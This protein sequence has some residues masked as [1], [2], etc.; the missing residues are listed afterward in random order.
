MS[1]WLV[2]FPDTTAPQVVMDFSGTDPQP[3]QLVIAGWVVDRKQAPA[4]DVSS[5][6][7][8]EVWVRPIA[9]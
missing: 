6:Y 3:G 9:A 8:L 2:H 1:P 4:P 7:A 5:E